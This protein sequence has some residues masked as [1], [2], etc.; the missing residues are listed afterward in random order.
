VLSCIALTGCASSLVYSPSLDLSPTPLKQNQ[1]QLMAAVEMLPETRP[2]EVRRY[3]T[4][5]LDGT[6][7]YGFSDRLSLQAKNWYDVRRQN[8]YVRSGISIS[9]TYLLSDRS[10]GNTMFALMPTVAFLFNGK[11]EDGEGIAFPVVVWLPSSE[12]MHLYAGLGPAFGGSTFF[13]HIDGYGLV[14]NVGV[15]MNLSRALTLNVELSGGLQV[16]RSESITH[17]IASPKASLGWLF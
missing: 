4:I 9:A 17:A 16:N 8:G 2:A 14:G 12:T 3:A 13:D 6:L 15:A 1:G 7:K 10:E 5:G 11:S